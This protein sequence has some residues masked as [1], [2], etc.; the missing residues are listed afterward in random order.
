M[1][2][3]FEPDRTSIFSDALTYKVLAA[4]A[5]GLTTAPFWN[6]TSPFVP[7]IV[8]L[9]A[10]R[11]TSRIASCEFSVDTEMLEFV[12]VANQIPVVPKNAPVV[13]VE[14]ETTESL[15]A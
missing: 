5:L 9:W 13:S 11:I 15:S 3:I 4:A 10:R 12:D 8:A 7:E 2:V 6:S 1:E 14:P